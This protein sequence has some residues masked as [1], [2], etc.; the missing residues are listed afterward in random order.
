MKTSSSIIFVLCLQAASSQEFGRRLAK[1]AKA[2]ATKAKAQKEAKG[3][4]NAV[5]IALEDVA[6]DMSVAYTPL[7]GKSA[8]GGVA[9]KNV[10][11]SAAVIR[12]IPTPVTDTTDEESQAQIYEANESV[13]A[14]S[15]ESSATA[16]VA[17]SFVIWGG[18]INV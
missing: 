10:V 1:S 5:E 12:A 8:K 16:F 13:S 3:S 18:L 15:T 17:L 11:S 6:N 4:V 7:A 2:T 14:A 9:E